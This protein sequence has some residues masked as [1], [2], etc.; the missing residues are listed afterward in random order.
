[1]SRTKGGYYSEAEAT[2][3]GCPEC[4]GSLDDEGRCRMCGCD[5]ED[6]Q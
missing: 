2:R 6:W 5:V 1:M 4:G 3:K